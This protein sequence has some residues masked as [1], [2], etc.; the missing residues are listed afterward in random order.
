MGQS[1][2]DGKLGNGLIFASHTPVQIYPSLVEVQ[3]SV[4]RAE[5]YPGDEV[6]VPIIM[7]ENIGF[8]ALE[9][10]LVIPEGFE[11]LEITAG[12]II[13]ILPS[14]E[15][16][17]LIFETPTN[18]DIVWNGILATLR[19]KA[20]RDVIPGESIVE[21]NSITARSATVRNLI[22]ASTPGTI[23]VKEPNVI[24]VIN[25]YDSG[26]AMASMTEA[27]PGESVALEAFIDRNDA[28]RT[29]NAN[30][31]TEG[32]YEFSHWEVISGGAV[33]ADIKSYAT[34]FT[35]PE[36]DVTIQAVFKEV[37]GP[38][39]VEVIANNGNMGYALTSHEQ[40]N[41]G[42]VV[43]IE[44]FTHQGDIENASV[45]V[46]WEVISG[47][48]VLSDSNASSTT[49]I[50]PDSSVK[51]QAVFKSLDYPVFADIFVNNENF[52]KVESSHW[53]TSP[54]SR[55][56]ISAI[57]FTGVAFRRWEVL[58]GAVSITDVNSSDTYFI[59]P[60]GDVSLRAVF[61]IPVGFSTITLESN[62][63]NWGTS[64]S[65]HVAATPGTVVTLAATS[66][67]VDGNFTFTG[68][69][70]I[71]GG[72]VVASPTSANTTFTMPS[73]AVSIRAVFEPGA[74]TGRVNV[75]SNNTEWGAVAA[76]HDAA[77]SGVS[78]DLHAVAYN[79]WDGIYEFVRWD[80]ISGSAVINNPNSPDTGF[81]M[82]VGNVSLQ[83]V[84]RPLANAMS[85]NVTSNNEDWGTAHAS[86]TV[87]VSGMEIELTAV[88]GWDEPFEFVSWEVL[89]GDVRIVD[90]YSPLTSFIMPAGNVSVRG[91]FKPM[92][93]PVFITI[94]EN[95]EAW[96]AVIS[97]HRVTTHGTTVEISAFPMPGLEFVQWETSTAGL[98]LTDHTSSDT[99]FTMP[100]NDV[101]IKAIFKIPPG[102]GLVKVS[103][104]NERQGLAVASHVAAIP[105]TEIFLD[106]IL[107]DVEEA[108]SFE[109]WEV[110]EGSV[111]LNNI[112]SS[113]TFF[114]MPD[115]DVSIRAIFHTPPPLH[116]VTPTITTTTLPNGTVGTFYSQTLA[117]TG[118]TPITWTVES[119]SLPTGFSLSTAGVI[120]GT[121]TVSGTF[122]F[123]VR[124]ENTAGNAT[125]AL[126]IAIINTTIPVTSVTLNRQTMTLEAGGT[127]TLT[128][129]VHP[130]NAAN[131]SVSWSSSNEAVATV[132]QSGTVTAVAVGTATITVTT[133][134]GNRTATCR[135]TV[136]DV[137]PT[138]I[139]L[140]QS[141]NAV[142]IDEAVTF[143]L[144]SMPTNSSLNGLV[145]EIRD[146]DNNIMSNSFFG[147]PL[148]P[149]GQTLTLTPTTEAKPGLYEI[150]A[151][152]GSLTARAKLTIHAEGDFSAELGS[153]N[154][155]MNL[156]KKELTV[157][158]QVLSIGTVS[159][160][161]KLPVTLLGTG[162][163]NF[164][165]ILDLNRSAIVL[166]QPFGITPRTARNL[167]VSVNNGGTE[168]FVFEDKLSITVTT[169]YPRIIWSLNMPLNAF[170]R[171]IEPTLTARLDDGSPVTITGITSTGAAAN[172]VT[173]NQDGTLKPIRAGTAG[174]RVTLEA[175]DYLS[176]VRPNATN[177][178]GNTVTY[179]ARVVNAAP[180]LRLSQ[181]SIGFLGTTN[182][183]TV[184]VLSN[185]ARVNINDIPIKSIE[186]TDRNAR[187]QIVGRYSHLER[188]GYS[189]GDRTVRLERTG[190]TTAGNSMLKVTF[191]GSGTNAV[192]LPLRVSLPSST[193]VRPT[194]RVSSVTVHHEQKPGLIANIPITTTPNLGLG[195]WHIKSVMQGRNDRTTQVLDVLE[196]AVSGGNL[197]LSLREGKSLTSLVPA[198]INT[199][200]TL[201]IG[202]GELTRTLSVRL[203][204]SVRAES[205]TV[206]LR[207]RVDIANPD[208]AI[209]ATVRLTNIAS[210]ISSVTLTNP[211][212]TTIASENQLYYAVKTGASTFAIRMVEEK[213]IYGEIIPGIQA[214]LGVTVTLANGDVI[215]LPANRPIRFTPARTA[216]RAAINKR[217]VTLF[218]N[219]PR[220]GEGFELHFTNIPDNISEVTLDTTGA[221]FFEV[222]RSGN[223]E[224]AIRFKD[225]VRPPVTLN[226][227]NY[228]VRLQVWA[229]G[230]HATD[231]EG[232]FAGAILNPANG[233]A[234]TKPTVVNLRVNLR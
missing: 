187:G 9:M 108:N 37:E 12:D 206:T 158:V 81:T 195:D 101:E 87:A 161:A 83:A 167:T 4:G 124:A 77:S 105:G 229:E 172:R 23:T 112:N 138:S 7:N 16:T 157:P 59:M 110:L 214:R 183:V 80:V 27:V 151:R 129:T 140:T 43:T 71:S 25:D 28:F 22:T 11:V 162:G 42:E 185:N 69:H 205:M 35:M 173:V 82:P 218:R 21:L 135:V 177:N 90:I 127:G 13:P 233:R 121:P 111:M 153:T 180:R 95:N 169:S 133:A 29:L 212:G 150:I 198:G 202:S 186:V 8:V 45:F 48:V 55:V 216:G 30:G 118:T 139:R 197:R 190:T 179:N 143:T 98:T 86:R 115:S 174:L 46:R 79:Q 182:E 132:S 99:C 155:T 119:G 165:A 144:M 24:T 10:N 41:P 126:S 193:A 36:S 32:E 109:R 201:H 154:M 63:P 217:A 134:D 228:T 211:D 196:T 149:T 67:D 120:S 142:K 210:E 62:N 163:E 61:E 125:R 130:A 56:E 232:N 65:S 113:N 51:I 47:E 215:S 199:T 128:A 49:F 225:G 207:D 53:A 164:N 204:V 100:A 107:F 19:L 220:S 200:Y 3:L 213:R 181:N 52:G 17:K 170:Y 39:I 208:S 20:S 89:E 40:A 175:D 1:Y 54:G 209:N 137:Q 78:V 222:S 147:A 70:V 73:G 58:T 102:A 94:T 68:W 18:N 184:E 114:V 194:S 221:G 75:S 33:I 103:S 85:L 123:T 104:N 231:H 191:E 50:M 160:T 223:N 159:P 97:S 116:I 131:K 88:S 106:A 219:A 168:L 74:E 66:H 178:N 234:M 171:D 192:F 176:L 34:A 93:N 224:W 230:T 117:A 6:E 92:E 60:T 122:N 226:K 44:A 146:K 15:S 141:T 26:E 64:T 31:E 188:I 57:P 5:I 84:F 227:A 152:L 148:N 91:I 145:W 136:T 38:P 2:P 76:S 203:I 96:G 166:T 156:A 14:S 72:A 189:E